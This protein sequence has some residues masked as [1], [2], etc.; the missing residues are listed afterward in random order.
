MSTS[1]PDTS[2]RPD[3]AVLQARH[4]EQVSVFRVHA[5]VY[6][7]STV[8]IFLVNLLI[9]LAAG[10]TGDLWAWWSFWVMIGW[11]LGI[12]VHGLTV[13]HY[14]ASTARI[15]RYSATDQGA[16]G[17]QPGD[18][19]PGSPGRP[20]DVALGPA[21]SPA[22]CGR[23]GRTDNIINDDSELTALC[24]ALRR[25]NTRPHSPRVSTTANRAWTGARTGT[26]RM[27]IR[28]VWASAHRPHFQCGCPLACVP[29]CSARASLG[30]SQYVRPERHLWGTRG[31]GPSGEPVTGNGRLSRAPNGRI[32]PNGL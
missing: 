16:E 11:G 3:D 19:S 14:L 31:A 24:Q 7:V 30:R 28:A 4:A 2:Q 21:R 15:D 10:L 29:I 20:T 27:V 8:A 23:S 9:N 22:Q 5:A 6:A 32:E 25:R 13:F 17:R 26:E 12:A 1:A 18:C